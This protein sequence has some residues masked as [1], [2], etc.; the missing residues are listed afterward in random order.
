MGKFRKWVGIVNKGD[1]YFVS[2]DPTKGSEQA[3]TR[4]CVIIQWNFLNAVLNTVIVIPITSSI[5]DKKYPNLVYVDDTSGLKKPG[6]AKVEQIRCVDKSRL[7]K[8]VGALTREQTLEIQKALQK[9]LDFE[10]LM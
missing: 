5:P 4:P 2:L 7:Q 10:E 3:K 9:V 8:K 6:I 1:I